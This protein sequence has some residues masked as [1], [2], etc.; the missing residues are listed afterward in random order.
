[1]NAYLKEIRDQPAALRRLRDF[2]AGNGA[3][4][5]Q[6][7]TRL[8]ERRGTTQVLISGMGSSLFAAYPAMRLLSERGVSASM[9]ETSEL[10]HYHTSGVP[11]GALVLLVSQSGE[12]IEMERLLQRI[13]GRDRFVAV[14][15]VAGSTLGRASA[16][17]LPIEAGPQLTEVSARTY[18]NTMATLLLAADALTGGTEMLGRL[19]PAADAMATFLST[20]DPLGDTM[21]DFTG[22][23]TSATVLARGP[24]LATAYQAAFNLKEIA[25]FSAE[26]M[27]AAQFRHG[28]IE[29]AAP[30]HT[31][32]VFAPLGSTFTLLRKLTEEMLGFGARVVFVTDTQES[33]RH[34]GENLLAVRHPHL[35]ETLAPLVNL[36]PLQLFANARAERYG[37]AAGRLS[38]ASAVMRVE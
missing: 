11:A 29:V 1:M 27:S 35:D 26:P 19:A 5:L 16:V 28:P 10:L 25:R 34:D 30:G 13:P 4:L 24:S 36:V 21:D 9:I 3:E 7:L 22:T 12:T 33:L 31:T 8:R 15:N 17:T 14:T 37:L 2:Y 20:S 6:A 32:I 18:H 38:K 23:P